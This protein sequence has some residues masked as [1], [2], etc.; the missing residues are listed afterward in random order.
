MFIETT[1]PGNQVKFRR[2]GMKRVPGSN[3]ST[4]RSYG[5]TEPLLL[6]PIELFL[7]PK[8]ERLAGNRWGGHKA[9]VK[10]VF[11]QFLEFP[12]ALDDRALAFFT[13]EI[14]TTLR[15]NGRRGIIASDPLAPN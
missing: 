7:C 6:D 2:S 1:A 14:N 9:V 13:E 12:A 8:E 11:G 3:S 4:C 15:I 10:F 5:A